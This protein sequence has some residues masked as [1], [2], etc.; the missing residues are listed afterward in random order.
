MTRWAAAAVALLMAATLGAQQPTSIVFEGG[1]VIVG[2]GVVL[3]KGAVVIDGGRIVSVGRMGEARVPLDATHIDISGKTV[4]PTLVDAHM[5]VGYE[6]MSSWRAENYSRQNVIDTLDREAYY[7]VGAVF[8]TGTDPSDLALA[9]QKEQA[10]GAIGGARLV[11]AAGFGPPGN[12]PNPQLLKELAKFPDV[13]VRGI[14]GDGDARQGIRDIAAKG[15]TF[16]KVWVTDRGGTQ[17]KTTPEAYRALIDEAHKHSIRVVAHGTDTLQDCKDLAR[18]GLDGSIHG[19]LDADAEYA[20]LMKKNNGFVTPAQ[21]LGWRAIPGEPPWFE[22]PFF[23]E[24]TPT[25]TVVRYRQQEAQRAGGVGPPAGNQPTFTQQLDRA[26]HMIQVLTAGGVRIAIGTDSGA[27]PDYP[28]GYPVHRELELESRMGM[29]PAQLVVSATKSGA[30]ALR[31]DKDLDTLE[32]GK[33]AN[34]VVLNANP[35]DD[36]RNTRRI[37]AVYIQ[38]SRLDREAMRRKWNP[39]QKS[40]STQRLAVSP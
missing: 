10:E 1:R 15:I 11:F 28:P 4:M 20:A 39:D 23:Q 31:L 3:E 12:G 34:L 13:V 24:A 26:K 35:L 17:K 21:G 36:I 19:V 25:A 2:N 38:G 29:T 16:A 33:V 37:A 30:E 40:Q 9:I 27:T 22:D 6:N 14:T 18:A 7:G 8:S 5:H 32:V